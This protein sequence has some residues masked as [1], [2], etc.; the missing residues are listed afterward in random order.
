MTV[1]SCLILQQAEGT[2]RRLKDVDSTFGW[3]K[4]QD[5]FLGRQQVQR[6]E[7]RGRS[8]HS[9]GLSVHTSL[10]RHCPQQG[11]SH[12]PALSGDGATPIYF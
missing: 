6:K 5:P 3:G 4:I 1:L 12:S 10:R 7:P 8:L 2:T 9:Q 11:C